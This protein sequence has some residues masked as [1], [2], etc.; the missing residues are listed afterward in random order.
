ML[1]PGGLEIPPKKSSTPFILAALAAAVI[2]GIIV[3]PKMFGDKPAP[4]T[5]NNS[6]ASNT[7]VPNNASNNTPE[8][9]PTDP[10]QQYIKRVQT[11]INS[12]NFVGAVEDL[13]KAPSKLPE[14]E[15]EALQKRLKEKFIAYLDEQLQSGTYGLA[16]VQLQDA[17]RGI[18]LTDDDKKQ[19]GDKIRSAWLANA[20][21]EFENGNTSTALDT[22]SNL[23]GKREFEN[24]RDALLL[25]AR[26]QI[27]LQNPAAAK[28]T[29]A[30]LGKPDDLPAELRPAVAGLTLL[31]TDTA[32]KPNWLNLLDEYLIYAAL[33]KSA[34]TGSF[35][36]N[37][38]E[39]SRLTNLREQIEQNVDYRALPAAKQ[40]EVLDK[41]GQLS[42][43]EY[44]LLA[45]V[46]QRL[47]SKQY[48]EARKALQE[49]SAKVPAEAEKL[50]AE[51]AGTNLLIDLRDSTSKPEAYDA[52][53]RARSNCTARSRRRCG[54]IYAEPPK[55]WHRFAAGAA[56]TGAGNGQQIARFGRRD[57]AAI[58]QAA[59]QEA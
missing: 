26:C 25:M 17:R 19:Q 49:L 33:E 48:A 18:G 3:V 46:R 16:L 29:L 1:G 39:R 27:R 13:D 59:R 57:V 14:F 8:P 32:G 47:D 4:N 36:L 28:A 43:S 24:D 40:Q 37:T 52:A 15:K 5:P 12:A 20:Q 2:A 51:V 9:E 21:S 53:M 7:T 10:N 58:R 56:G 55:R 50:K 45:K 6:I 23:L 22:V 34:T 38:W 54:A 44:V 31:A 11:K 41:L 35:A 30:K 42:S